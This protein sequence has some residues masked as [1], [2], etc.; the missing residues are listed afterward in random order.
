M[1]ALS[2]NISEYMDNV[3]GSEFLNNYLEFVES[4]YPT[5]IRLAANDIPVS[6][7]IESLRR[8]GIILER[9]DGI[10]NAYAVKEG[11]D[12]IGK[13]IEHTLGKY[14]I[15]SL[16]SMIP[17]LIL[18]PTSNDTV[19]DLCAAPGSKSTE[20][21]ELMEFGGT[22]YSN[23]PNLN[24][25]KALVHNLDKMNSLNMSVIKGKGEL[26]SK[27]FPEFFDKI[28][29]DAPCSA[30]GVVQKKQ[31]VSNWWSAKSVD[32][33]SSLQLRLLISAIKM[34]KVGGEIVYSTCTM[35]V[36]ENE[37]IIDKVLQKYP[38]ELVDF[39]LKVPHIEG[40]ATISDYKFN[41]NLKLTKRILPWEL[42]SEGFFIAK[43]IKNGVTENSIVRSK[44]NDDRKKIVNAG[45][46]RIKNYLIGL[47][48]Y[49]GFD[50]KI[51]SEYKFVINKND[52]NFIN[53]DSIVENPD[54][55]LRIGTK[56]GIIDKND[57]IKLHSHAAQILGKYAV[58]N[59]FSLKNDL[60]LKTYFSGGIIN[61]TD[62]SNGQKIVKFNKFF[63]GTGI[64]INNQL[65]SQFPRSKRTGEIKV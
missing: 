33:I 38:V 54:Y 40:F 63:V 50:P 3:F 5:T 24:R 56:F 28:L 37:Y 16:S 26:L 8:Q 32:K 31:E 15:Q 51:F 52:I 59:V 39:E 61:G 17:P 35:T 64:A 11:D 4:R 34:A 45:D 36:E 18:N 23:E 49:F 55:F 58:K 48:D 14:Y 25:I 43:L 1:I 44:S 20:L 19:L 41:N 10:K 46:K 65:K 29:V 22:L 21:A 7:L 13:T 60:E 9:I 30:L 27:D 2:D 47:S 12:I 6:E 57:S 42:K 62:T 53:A